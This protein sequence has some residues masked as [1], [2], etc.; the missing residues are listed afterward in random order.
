MIEKGGKNRVKSVSGRRRER[1]KE[2]SRVKEG[3]RNSGRK[4]RK[5]IQKR[6]IA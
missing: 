4:L 3:E 5:R 2:R 1:E 6:K